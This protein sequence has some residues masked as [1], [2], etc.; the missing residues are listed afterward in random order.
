MNGRVYDPIVG[1]FVSP[2]PWIQDPKNSQSFN[3]YSY[4]W[5]NPLRYTDPSGEVTKALVTMGKILHKLKNKYDKNGKFDKD[6]VG[7]TLKG[8]GMDMLDDAM[9]LADSDAGILDKGAATLD[10]L[11]G[12]ELNN[13]K[14]NTK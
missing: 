3:R 13:K 7:E 4:V 2:D 6:S 5:N 8:E 14:V 1:R 9:T 12:T 11:L 10:L